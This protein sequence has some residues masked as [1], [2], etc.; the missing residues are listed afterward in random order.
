MTLYELTYLARDEADPGVGTAL[1]AA[2][3]RLMNERLLGRRTL[4]YP[5]AKQTAGYYTTLRF[6]AEPSVVAELNRTLNLNPGVLRFL[7]VTVPEIKLEP[8]SLETGELKEAKE[9]ETA[10]PTD[11]TTPTTPVKIVGDEASR[12]KQLDEQLGKLLSDTPAAE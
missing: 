9:L 1:E 3:A 12:S 7:I 5:I 10:P 2:Q 4:A 8:A 11:T 6:Q